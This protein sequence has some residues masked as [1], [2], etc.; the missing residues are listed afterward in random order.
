MSENAVVLIV[1]D[2]PRTI[3]GIYSI[4]KKKKADKWGVMTAKNAL[5]AMEYI[6]NRKIDLMLL[7]INMPEMDGISLLKLLREKNITITTILLTGHADFDYACSAIRMNVFNY[8]LKPIDKDILVKEVE[9]G[10]SYNKE[11]IRLEKGAKILKDHPE[12]FEEAEVDT[13]NPIIKKA[14]QI[15]NENISRSITLKSLAEKVHVNDCYLSVIFKEEMGI[16]FTDYLTNLRL[17]KAKQL[18]IENNL[19][20]YEIAE[21]AG[22]HSAKYFSKVFHDHEGLT[23]NQF[24]KKFIG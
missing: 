24:R 21:E 14:C 4:L 13:N 17:K 11:R 15:I 20:I 22:Y 6:N 1:D 23:P 18:L 3:K 10:I 16:T 9:K 8:L 12:L 19:K 7:D 5:E 2:E